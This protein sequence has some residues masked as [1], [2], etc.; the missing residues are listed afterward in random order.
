MTGANAA[1]LVVEELTKE[2][3]EEQVRE[4]SKLLNNL[5]KNL[6]N[7]KTVLEDDLRDCLQEDQD[8]GQSP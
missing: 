7:K 4:E 5:K 1:P 6:V 3:R 8:A 2:Q